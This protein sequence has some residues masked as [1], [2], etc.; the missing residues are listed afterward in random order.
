MN[1]TVDHTNEAYWNLVADDYDR[2]FPDT[3]VG[4]VQRDAVWYELDRHFEHGM[5]ILELNCGTGIDAV[6]LAKRGVRVL[7]CDLSPR[8]IDHARER[9]HT[10][11]LDALIDLRVLN[12]EKMDTLTA[13]EPFDG[14]L[15]NFSGL[16][17]VRDIAQ[18]ADNLARL[19]KPGAKVLLCM[20][21][22][23]SAWESVWH[24]AHGKPVLALRSFRRKPTSIPGRAAGL[25]HYPSVS[26][27]RRMFAPK[28]RLRDWKGIGVAVPPSCLD[29]VARTVP[30]LV[31]GLATIDCHLSRL[32]ILRSMG[33]CVLLQFD[34]LSEEF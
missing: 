1:T 4:K 12:T 26:D 10:A 9:A 11:G 14:A 31:G 27:M 16:N 17:C 13:D 15:S 2:I 18:V 28:F 19:L 33:D 30:T 21:G 23:F 22:R 34:R 6:H 29:P 32:P 20:V 5:R 24:L 3:I 8:M 7:A 25:V